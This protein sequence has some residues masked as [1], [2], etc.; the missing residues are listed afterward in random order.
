MRATMSADDLIGLEPAPDAPT[1]AAAATAE[2]DAEPVPVMD[3]V[4]RLGLLKHS[5]EPSPFATPVTAAGGTPAV[6]TVDPDPDDP[7]IANAVATPQPQH[8]G[9]IGWL[10]RNSD[11]GK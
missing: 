6:R 10:R 3:P 5:P 7:S 4:A 8:S 1:G 11:Q 9:P 2:G